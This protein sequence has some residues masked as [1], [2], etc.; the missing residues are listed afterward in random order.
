MPLI[1]RLAIE[2]NRDTT[3]WYTTL[4]KLSVEVSENFDTIYQRPT[5][6]RAK[7]SLHLYIYLKPYV[8]YKL[9]DKILRT[10]NH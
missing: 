2:E 4:K 5:H 1:F 10:S 3:S 9:V 7:V 6:Y 8:H